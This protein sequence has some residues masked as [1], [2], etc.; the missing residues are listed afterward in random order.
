MLQ[1]QLPHSPGG[2]LSPPQCVP[3]NPAARRQLQVYLQT[4]AALKDL[5]HARAA[6]NRAETEAG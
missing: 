5:M 3:G 1:N 2:V 6:L 4:H